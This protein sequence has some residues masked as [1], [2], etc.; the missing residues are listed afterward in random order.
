LPKKES[1][2]TQE[3]GGFFMRGSFSIRLAL[4]FLIV[5]HSALSQAAS[6]KQPKESVDVIII[7]AGLSGLSTAYYLKKAGISY[8]LLEMSPHIGGRIR[9]AKYSNGTSAEVGLEEFWGDNPALDICRD[10]KVP[11][12]KSDISF[13]SYV[14]EGKLI[15]FLMDGHEKFLKSNFNTQEYEA[16]HKWDQKMIQLEKELQETPISPEMMKLK[17]ISFG[18]WVKK[19]PGLT[20]KVQ[21]FIRIMSEPEYA[22]SWEN[23]SALDGIE[24]WHIFSGRGI[25]AHHVIGGNQRLAEAIAENIGLDQISLNTR[26]TRVQSHKNKVIVTTSNMGTFQ[27]AV[28][29]GKYVVS[30]IPL[31]R[32]GELQFDPPLSKE[33]KAAIQS[34]T[35][36][37]YF[38]AHVTLDAKAKSYW[39]H[40]ETSYLPILSDG[41]LGVIYGENPSEENNS[42]TL[43]NLLIAGSQAERLNFRA[44]A[45]NEIR[46]E[47]TEALEKLWPGIKKYVES[48]EFYPYHPRAIASWPVGRSRYDSQSNLIRKPEGRVYFAGDFTE[49]THSDG[50]VK[51]AIRVSRDILKLEKKPV[52]ALIS[53]H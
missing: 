16:F 32:V 37:S 34:Q 27:E 44:V 30:T 46:T 38:T 41:P 12:E 2:V 39:I 50:A 31:Y 33:R 6:Q 19:E 23:I 47:L 45:M 25:P 40:D 29:E 26:A 49:G 4:S 22:T 11:T 52:P 20:P 21:N 28:Y 1:F 8:H 13:S 35:W 48:F 9:T 17:D 7:G 15:P 36:G 53:G 14:Y 51:S 24:E 43:L 10:L 5:F 3:K 18:A 42:K